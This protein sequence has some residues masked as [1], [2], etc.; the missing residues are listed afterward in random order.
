[1]IGH[2]EQ[3][4]AMSR[5]ASANGA[6]TSIRTLAER[7]INA[8]QDEI[9]L[10]QRWLR[11][12]GLPVPEPRAADTAMH[13]DGGTHETMPGMLTGAQMQQLDAARSAQFDRLFLTFMIQHHNGAIAMVDELIR[14]PGA[15]QDRS[16]F[17][18]ASDVNVDQSTEVARMSKMLAALILERPPQ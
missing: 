14:S 11:D 4:I 17:K 8:Q 13:H 10:M 15:A 18:L 6:S 5:L 1:M 16:V 7:I 12:R 9:A 3:A 2:H